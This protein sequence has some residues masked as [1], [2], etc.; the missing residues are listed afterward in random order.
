MGEVGVVTV[1]PVLWREAS[2]KHAKK[3]LFGSL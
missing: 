2:Q 3:L 1:G